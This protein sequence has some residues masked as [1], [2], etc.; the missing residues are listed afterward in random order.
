VSILLPTPL[1]VVGGWQVADW[2]D[3]S[4]VSDP[5]GA[6]G[7]ALLTLPTVPDGERWQLTHMVCAC[8]S[9]AATRMRLYF[10]AVN[11][12]NFRDGSLSGNFDVA[13]WPQ[14]LWVPPGR[15]LLA[16]WTGADPGT[17]GTLTLQAVLFR[18]T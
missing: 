12:R 4:Y 13:D 2:L 18:R 7:V 5:A 11:D 9:T 15:T 14:G 16:R 6:D 8:T 1:P 3:R 10:D 17:V